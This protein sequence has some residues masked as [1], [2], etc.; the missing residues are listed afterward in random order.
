LWVQTWKDTTS[1]NILF[2][3]EELLINK[4]PSK[5]HRFR[6]FAKHLFFNTTINSFLTLYYLLTCRS[7]FN[8]FRFIR[9]FNKS[10]VE[11]YYK[12]FFNFKSGRFFVS[13]LNSKG[14]LYSSLSVGLFLKFFENKKSLKKKK[15]LKLLLAKYVRKLLII[16]NIRNIYLYIRKTPTHLYEICNLLTSPLPKPFF[17]PIKGHPVNE[18][19]ISH[20]N[21][22]IRYIFFTKIKSYTSMKVARKG[23]LKRKIQRRILKSNKITD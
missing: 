13:I 5:V 4:H 2:E 9:Q 6:F 10:Y 3:I 17:N 16:S 12:I 14:R 1:I 7:F 8:F 19:I 15:I 11:G 23:R 20:H 18:S 21:L 22:N